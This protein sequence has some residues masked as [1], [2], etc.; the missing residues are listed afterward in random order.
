MLYYFHN[1]VK[2]VL[3]GLLEVYDIQNIYSH[4]EVGNKK[5]Y[6]RDLD[7]QSLCKEHHIIWKEFQ[8]HGVIRKLKSRK[9]GSSAGNKP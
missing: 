3:L 2:P 1:E 4:L 6:D 9:I 5:T 7:I 8:I